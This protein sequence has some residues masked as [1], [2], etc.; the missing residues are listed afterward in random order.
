MPIPFDLQ[1]KFDPVV[2]NIKATHAPS[3]HTFQGDEI[4]GVSNTLNQAVKV[5]RKALKSTALSNPIS[6]IIQV[7]HPR[8]NTREQVAQTLPM[9][10]KG[11]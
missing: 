8:F 10:L 11:K 7:K 3:Y 1:I 2:S 6:F 4:I 9:L 5:I